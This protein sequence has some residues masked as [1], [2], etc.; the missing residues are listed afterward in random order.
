M[1][2]RLNREGRQGSVEPA[3]EN[4]YRYT[5]RLNDP[6]EAVPWLRTFLGRIESMSCDDPVLVKR[7]QR[8]L[9]QMRRIYKIAEPPDSS[10]G[11]RQTELAAEGSIREE[12]KA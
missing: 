6:N 11:R 2:A 8:D 4:L 1:L 10:D 7:F 12:G 9:E 5:V 3:G